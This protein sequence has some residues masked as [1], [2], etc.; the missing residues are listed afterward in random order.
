MGYC[1]S[2]DGIID[3]IGNVFTKE[4]RTEHQSLL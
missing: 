1:F 4:G 2:T 3:L